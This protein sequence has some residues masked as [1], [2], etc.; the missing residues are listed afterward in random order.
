MTT[1]Q[2]FLA[3]ALTLSW[4][5]A[6]IDPSDRAGWLLEN[7]LVFIF[8]PVIILMGRYFRISEFSWTFLTLFMIL[9][10]TGSH[11]TYANVP[12]GD[13]LADIIGSSRNLFD[14]IV[15]FSFGL[16]LAYPIREVFIRLTGA[17]G[18]WSYYFPFDIILS[19]S[20]LY[21]I[22]EWLTA[23]AVSS[24]D[25]A[26]F[27]GSQGDF[28][29]TQKDMSAAAIGAVIAITVIFVINMRRN[30]GFL[31]EMRESFRIGE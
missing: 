16:L 19:L 6:A 7:I 22:F 14:R 3:S 15:H 1:Y 5:I 28:W 20:A 25:A 13:T 11:W 21:E 2:K 27:I 30:G 4:V 18:F 31:R 29:D 23:L 9:H 17:K 26:V 12:A 8:V 24:K 10:I